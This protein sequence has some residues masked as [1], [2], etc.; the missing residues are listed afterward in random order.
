ME[1]WMRANDVREVWVGADN[2]TAVEFYRANG[3]TAEDA[4]DTDI[5][6][7]RGSVFMSKNV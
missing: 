7:H 1:A 2:A 4:G 6:A 3:F 5:T